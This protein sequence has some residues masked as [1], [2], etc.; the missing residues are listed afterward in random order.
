MAG[1]M[2]ILRKV[3]ISNMKSPK[4]S[5]M[6]SKMVS[7]EYKTTRCGHCGKFGHGHEKHEQDEANKLYILAR[8]GKVDPRFK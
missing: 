1:P 4:K 2:K 7:K 8:T 3:I 6:A 5:S